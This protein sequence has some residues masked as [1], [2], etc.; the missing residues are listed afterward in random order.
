MTLPEAMTA[1]RA[2]PKS[3]VAWSEL[4]DALVG[5][6]QLEKARESYQR[7]LQ[8]DPLCTA[9][10][11]GLAATLRQ[12]AVEEVPLLDTVEEEE[13]P[14][15]ARPVRA[16]ESQ[17]QPGAGAA[18]GRRFRQE[19][20]PWPEKPARARMMVGLFLLIVLPSTCLCAGFLALARLI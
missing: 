10:Q 18:S 16:A 8:L 6:G 13:W 17:A 2:N 4:G 5:E 15:V 7:A 3:A 20:P 14:A 19:V 11:V 9:A 12:P 1:V